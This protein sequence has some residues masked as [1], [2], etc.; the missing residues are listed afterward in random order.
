MQRVAEVQLLPHAKPPNIANQRVGV[1]GL[2][3]AWGDVDE[4][5]VE[6]ARLTEVAAPVVSAT[7]AAAWN[8]EALQKQSIR[9]EHNALELER[10]VP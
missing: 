2:F 3:S 10:R 7:G 6:T 1:W 8:I 5:W 9:D 4:A